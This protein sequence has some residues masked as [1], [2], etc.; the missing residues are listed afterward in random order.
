MNTVKLIKVEKID[1]N[2]IHEIIKRILSVLDP[3]KIVIFGSWARGTAQKGSDLDILVVI[4]D[5]ISRYE[6][7]VKVYKSLQ[8]IL[9]SKDIVVTTPQII[10]DWADIPQAFITTVLR[11]GQVVYEKNN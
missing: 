11:T 3:I 6:S 8:G 5:G 10:N 4:N 7:T 2:L 9:I 1:Q